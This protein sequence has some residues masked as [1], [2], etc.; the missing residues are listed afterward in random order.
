MENR[1]DL[2][3]LSNEIRQLYHSDPET[4]AGRIELLLSQRLQSFSNQ[5]KPAIINHLQSCFSSVNQKPFAGQ[6]GLETEILGKISALLLGSEV[7]RSELSNGELVERLIQA[8]NTVFNT[9]N[10]LIGVINQTF[11]EGI[12]DQTLR[13][14]IRG[15]LEDKASGQAL[16]QSLEN[17]LG[18][19]SQAFLTTNK[20]FKM[21]AR[22][23]VDQI[24]RELD[25]ARIAA[26][27]GGGL[28]FGPLRKAELFNIYEEK[29]SK[30]KRWVDS[31][32][33]LEELERTFER[34]CRSITNRTITNK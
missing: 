30:F 20:A 29:Y 4:A 10:N 8:V 33:F 25:P 31:G 9:L 2:D 28:K 34:N 23:K 27:K 32:R 3:A 18:Q 13:Q 26:E 14:V 11:G 1:I 15:Q 17:Y 6:D 21:A 22:E 12:G 24:F 19:I 7:I 5:D 16:E